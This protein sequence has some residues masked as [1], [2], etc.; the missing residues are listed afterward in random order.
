MKPQDAN[1]MES[2]TGEIPAQNPL[3]A[4]KEEDAH[5]EKIKKESMRYPAVRRRRKI[6]LIVTCAVVL[7]AGLLAF[8][9]ISNVR[10]QSAE[11][12]YQ[13]QQYED[14]Y[15]IYKTLIIKDSAKKAEECLFIMLK[16]SIPDLSVGSTFQFGSYEQDNDVL[17]GKEE[18][19]WTVLAVDGRKALIISTYA[20]DCRRY[21][22]LAE[23]ITWEACSLRTWLNKTFYSK[24]F[25]TAH[26]RMIVDTHLTAEDNTY[27]ETPG[28]N[29]TVDKVFLLTLS[30]AKKYLSSDEERQCSPTKYAVKRGASVKSKGPENSSV[31]YW[32]LRTPGK[33][34]VDSIAVDY[35]GGMIIDG[36]RVFDSNKAVRP[37]MWIDLDA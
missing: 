19:D 11:E 29:D 8:V 37:A 16:A 13:A 32:W 36:Y 5:L 26:Q 17:N 3:D 20:L 15:R 6:I 10:Y 9:I 34:P 24:A 27:Y 23:H 2:E 12:L 7:I 28:G 14:A 33:L 21:H 18:I 1:R 25:S 22:G 4:R 31:T 35:Y 30:E